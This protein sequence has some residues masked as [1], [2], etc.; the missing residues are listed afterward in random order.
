M[1]KS[2]L[3]PTIANNRLTIKQGKKSFQ[4]ILP[5]DAVIIALQFVFVSRGATKCS[6]RAMWSPPEAGG[7]G[8]TVVSC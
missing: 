3:R 8:E 2:E 1:V 6:S 5:S 7:G 4:I